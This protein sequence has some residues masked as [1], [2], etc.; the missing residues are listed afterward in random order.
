MP[1]N[2][3]L[4]RTSS[5]VIISVLALLLLAPVHGNVRN[6]GTLAAGDFSISVSPSSLNVLQGSA[7]TTTVIVSSLVN[8]SSPVNLGVS[9]LPSG[10]VAGFGTNP[11]TPPL[12]GTASS[13]LIIS[14]GSSVPVVH[15][16]THRYWDKRHHLSFDFSHLEGNWV[17][18][19][20]DHSFP[21]KCN[22][23]TQRDRIGNSYRSIFR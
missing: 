7:G 3:R 12:G 13:P 17:G 20:H 5:L 16:S 9:G 22:C 6:I 1:Q 21:S 2:S 14:V 15:V 4:T 18:R 23:R 11:V 19:F 8:F 10:A